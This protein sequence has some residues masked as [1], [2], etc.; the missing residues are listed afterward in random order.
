MQYISQCFFSQDSSQEKQVHILWLCAISPQPS[1]EREGYTT[2]SFE[3]W[4]ANIL[5]M[6]TVKP[7]LF[8]FKIFMASSQG[9]L[10]HIS[11]QA[12]QSNHSINHE[13]VTPVW[14]TYNIIICR[15][16]TQ[17]FDMRFHNCCHTFLVWIWD[18]IIY[19]NSLYGSIYYDKKETCI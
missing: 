14:Y 16:W 12:D 9:I 7:K 15:N 3:A 13:F 18:Q 19:V 10:S 5:F 1:G 4:I 8:G 11:C 17:F 6:S 2:I